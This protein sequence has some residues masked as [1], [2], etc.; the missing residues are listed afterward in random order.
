MGGGLAPSWKQVG[1]KWHQS[2]TP[3][4][5]KNMIGFWIP[6]GPIL[7]DLGIQFGR[8]RGWA[9]S[10]LENIF[11]VKCGGTRFNFSLPL[12]ELEGKP[13]SP[14]GL[15]VSEPILGVS[16]F[17]RSISGR[18]E[19]K[20]VGG[21]RFLNRA[22]LQVASSLAPKRGGRGWDEWGPNALF[23]LLGPRWP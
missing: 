21:W 2:P 4:P 3:K 17:D 14:K 20:N 6:S 12:K 22:C 10:L 16:T 11:P 23:W 18:L 5:M 13:R 8:S 1:T 15:G 19:W 9:K 7:V